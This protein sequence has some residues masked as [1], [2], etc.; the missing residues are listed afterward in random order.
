MNNAYLERA[1]LKITDPKIL[2]IIT[3][4][5]AKQ[6]AL[7]MRPM[8][9]CDSENWLDVALLEI[10]EGKLYYEFSDTPEEDIF[11]EAANTSEKE[12]R[13]AESPKAKA[14]AKDIFAAV[15]VKTEVADAPAEKSED[16]AASK[17]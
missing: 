13:T 10:A 1:K 17:E 7:G 5:R 14:A 3:A 8:V 2:S 11:A 6:L 12:T 9:K 16:S 4:K 15:E